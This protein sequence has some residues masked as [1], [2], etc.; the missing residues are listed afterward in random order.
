MGMDLLDMKVIAD[1]IW[2]R[3]HWALRGFILYVERADLCLQT[4]VCPPKDCCVWCH[5]PE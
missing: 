1:S 2:K 3:S 4:S 5:V